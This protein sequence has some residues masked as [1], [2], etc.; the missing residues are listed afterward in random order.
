MTVDAVT[1]ARHA[2]PG[3]SAWQGAAEQ[4]ILGH[5]RQGEKTMDTYRAAGV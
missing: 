5:G 1:V 2:A 3:Q 4:M